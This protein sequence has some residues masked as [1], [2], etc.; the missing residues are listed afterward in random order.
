MITAPAGMVAVRV[1]TASTG[2]V[3]LMVLGPPLG[4]QDSHA[5]VTVVNAMI[6]RT[7]VEQPQAV[8]LRVEVMVQV[9]MP[10]SQESQT[11]T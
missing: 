5:R 7:S 11:S 10:P 3:T 1:V 9:V 4:P 6:G 8:V 2:M